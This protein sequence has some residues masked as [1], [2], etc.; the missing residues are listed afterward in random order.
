MINKVAFTP[1]MSIAEVPEKEVSFKGL[2]KEDAKEDNSA[3]I[4]GS[5]AALGAFGLGML[6]GKPKVVEKTVEKTVEKA[7]ETVTETAKD[8]VKKLPKK[9]RIKHTSPNKNP[10]PITNERE[11]EIVSNIDTKYANS[12]SRKLAD[13]AS[14]NVVTPEMQKKYDR[15]IAYQ[16]PTAKEKNDISELHKK[17]KKERAKKNAL[18]NQISN[19]EKIDI[20]RIKV[21]SGIEEVI[22]KKLKDGGHIHANGNIYFTKG[23]KIIQ[24]NVK[25]DGR[26]ITDEKKIAKHLANNE[27]CVVDLF[28]EKELKELL[29][30]KEVKEI[31]SNAA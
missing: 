3:L 17:N 20:Q 29:A 31:L 5:L 24:I 22:A 18:G 2:P 30:Q 23:G 7:S 13:E 26:V 6:V 28:S 15:E 19:Q 27:I 9:R 10:K 1:T 16:T 8:V 14:D 21:I 4:Y 11:A 25:S 12:S